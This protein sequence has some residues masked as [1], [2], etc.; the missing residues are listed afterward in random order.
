VEWEKKIAKQI[1]KV[2]NVILI[3][4]LWHAVSTFCENKIVNAKEKVLFSCRQLV[5]LY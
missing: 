3:V 4:F 1:R 5:K 2:Q